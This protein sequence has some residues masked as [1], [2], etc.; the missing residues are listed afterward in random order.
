MKLQ[1]IRALQD[2]APGNISISTIMI[3]SSMSVIIIVMK[4]PLLHACRLRPSPAPRAPMSRVKGRFIS[5]Q[6]PIL[7]KFCT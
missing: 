3:T 4:V 2:A 6:L 5:I 7:M 1:L